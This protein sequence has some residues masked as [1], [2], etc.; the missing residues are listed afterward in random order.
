VDDH[1]TCV[2]TSKTECIANGGTWSSANGT[3][4]KNCVAGGRIECLNLRGSERSTCI[5]DYRKK[6]TG[7]G[8]G[9][10]S[11]SGGDSGDQTGDKPTAKEICSKYGT[12]KPATQCKLGRIYY[13]RCMS[14]EQREKCDADLARILGI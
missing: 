5:N 12:N 7:S 4:P 1:D 8:G 6:C 10:G 13:G 3:Y 11:G 2:T 9:S 14:L